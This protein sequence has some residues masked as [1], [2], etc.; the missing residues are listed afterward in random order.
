MSQICLVYM[1]WMRSRRR[2]YCWGIVKSWHQRPVQVMKNLVV[3]VD[4]PDFGE[5]VSKIYE[6]EVFLRDISRWRL[7]MWKLLVNP[8]CFL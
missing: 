5:F 6:R 8:S 1:M 4:C 7:F 3:C 2:K